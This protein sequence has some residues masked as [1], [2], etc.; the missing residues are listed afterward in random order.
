MVMNSE[1]YAASKEI[2]YCPFKASNTTGAVTLNLR[3][4]YSLLRFNFIR[5]VTDV[6]LNKESIPGTVRSAHLHFLRL[7]GSPEH[8]ICLQGSLKEECRG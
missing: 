3:R 2:Y 7:Y 4:A 5:G 1:L 8:W 6:A